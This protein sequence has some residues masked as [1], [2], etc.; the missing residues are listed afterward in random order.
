MAAERRS[1]LT[2]RL[3]LLW[4]K[5][6]AGGVSTETLQSILDETMANSA[7]GLASRLREDGP[8]MLA[9]HAEFRRTFEAELRERWQPALDLFEMVL[10][11]CT[12]A[13]SDLSESLSELDE[14]VHPNKLRA[15]T[16]LDARACM[17]A[18]EIYSLLCSG[19]APG[20]QARWRTLHELA[21]IAFVLSE[22]DHELARRFLLHGQVERWKE[23]QCYQENCAALGLEPFSKEEMD[24]FRSDRDAVVNSFEVGYE[25]DWGWSK[26]AFKSALQRP[27]F[28]DLETLAGL[29]HY[30]PFVK[31]S[32]HAIHGGSSG[33]TDILTLHGHGQFMLAGPSDG[34]LSDPGHG[35]LIALYQ[36]TV[37]FL[38]NGPN[39]VR[40]EELL[41]L[42]GIAHLVSDA[43]VAFGECHAEVEASREAGEGEDLEPQFGDSCDGL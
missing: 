41:A 8:G 26:P 29:G 18:S 10:V 9:E 32:H 25:R 43:G 40:A 20:A 5:G 33:T 2:Q 19:H 4:E 11:A 34:G 23:A 36:V 37:A 24:S 16:L 35:A 38:L 3:A 39:E 1:E 14:S 12:E 17:V 6:R 28:E 15:L 30:K 27:N 22:G 7:S 42:M 31:L 13:G 21:V